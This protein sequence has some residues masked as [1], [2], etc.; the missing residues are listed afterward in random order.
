[1]QKKDEEMWMMGM[2]VYD[3]VAVAVE[4]NLA[5]RKAQSK[6]Y[7]KPLM[8]IHQEENDEKMKKLKVQQVFAQLEVM[9]VNHELNQQGKE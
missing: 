4:H 8:Q 5:G 1:M 7:D 3:A 9:R 2:Y 6:Y